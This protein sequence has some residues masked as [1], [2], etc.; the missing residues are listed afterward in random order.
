MNTQHSPHVLGIDAGNTK[1]IALLARLD[2][3]VIGAGRAGCGDIYGA[4]SEAAAIAEI[5][6][7]V[8][9]A[10]REAGAAIVPIAAC[11]LSAA[12]A[13]WPEDFVFFRDAMRDHGIHA[14]ALVVNDAFGALWAGLPYGPG[15]VVVCGTGTATGARGVDGRIWHTSF[16]Q[17]PHGSEDLAKQTLRAVWRAEL[18]LEPPT[19]LTEIVRRFFGVED[20]GE[21]LHLLTRRGHK[22]HVNIRPLAHRL[23]DAASAGDAVARRIVLEHGAGLGDYALAAARKV[24]IAEQPFTLVLAGG[25]LRHHAGMLVDAL[26]AR[27]RTGSPLVQVTRARFEPALGAVLMA[28]DRA[29][30]TIDDALVERLAASAPPASF[31]ATASLVNDE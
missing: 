27:V 2:G 18:G 25:T 19:A 14:D 30:V 26:V 1:T 9:A 22:P 13:D 20:A 29:G 31:F 16:W 4:V 15:V 8:R 3:L 23:L 6:S 12:G 11:A 28:L 10:R 24:G 5:V 7:A 17:G 21:A